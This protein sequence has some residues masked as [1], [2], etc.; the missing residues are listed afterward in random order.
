MKINSIFIIIALAV[1]GGVTFYTHK[2]GITSFSSLKESANLS[3]FI[4]DITYSNI[5][6]GLQLAGTLTVPHSTTPCPAIILV[7]GTGRHERNGTVKGHHEL[8]TAIA[9]Y[10]TGKGI[11]VLRYDK[12]GVG[13]SEGTFDTRL[14][15]HDFASDVKAG[16]TYLKTRSEI[17]LNKIGLLGHSEGGLIVCMV[18]TESNDLAFLVLMAGAATTKIDDIVEQACMQLHADGATEE[19]IALDR[20]IRTKMLSIV[21]KKSDIEIADKLLHQVVGKY[22]TELTPEQTAQAELLAFET[23]QPFF[24]PQAPVYAISKLNSEVMIQIFNSPWTRFLLSYDAIGALR[25]ITIPVAIINGESDFIVAE[26]ITTPIFEKN[27]IHAPYV[28]M[29]KIPKVNHFFET[30]KNGS[31]NEYGK[32]TEAISPIFLQVVGDQIKQMLKV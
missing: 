3:Y 4:E 24:E 15:S 10:L 1:I 27:L 31:M 17:D 8:F 19:M 22:L 11:A 6:S 28:A 30:C 12:R 25:K 20:K 14:T 9:D 5:E 13:Q 29:V 18:A 21:H 32:T 7:A 26:K 16:L 2:N 23:S